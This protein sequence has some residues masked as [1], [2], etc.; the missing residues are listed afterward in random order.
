MTKISKKL[1]ALATAIAV[2]SFALAVG[3]TKYEISK[4]PAEQRASMSDFDWIGADW[5]GVGI[6]FLAIALI[7]SLAALAIWFKHRHIE[8]AY[9]K[10]IN[11]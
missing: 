9:Q 10:L 1:L 3:G 6:L 7:L 4:I 5:V 11:K 2:F 8:S